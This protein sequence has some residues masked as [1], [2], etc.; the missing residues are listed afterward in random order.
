LDLHQTTFAMGEAVAH[1]HALWH[2]G[3]LLR[4]NGTDG[5]WRFSPASLGRS[6]A[7]GDIAIPAV[8]AR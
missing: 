2:R 7:F 3:E 5:V 4:R 8:G 1:L 6:I